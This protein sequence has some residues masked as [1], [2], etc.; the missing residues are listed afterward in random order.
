[1]LKQKK[2]FQLPP[3]LRNHHGTLRTVGFEI[4]FGSL[5]A[6][7]VANF[8]QSAFGGNLEEIAPDQFVVAD[9]S[10]GDFSVK[11]DTRIGSDPNPT[12]SPLQ[13]ELYKAARIALSVV[14]PHEI[15]TPPV[16]IDR[17]DELLPMMAMLRSAGAAGSGESVLY[18]FALHINPEATSFEAEDIALTLKSFSL[19]SPWLWKSIGPDMTRR[20]LGFAE[21]F[22]RLYV[23]KLVR[24]DYWPSLPNLIDDYID[25]NPSRNRDL[26]PLP[27]FTFLDEERVRTK[28]PNEKIGKRPTF[29][30]RL[31]DARVNDPNWS[32]ATEWNRWV[33]VER[34][35]ADREK[36]LV[37]CMSYL[38]C[39][40]DNDAWCSQ[41]PGFVLK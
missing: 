9:T 25:A 8:V 33:A 14:I 24:E 27:L 10:L 26:D 38:R 2:N 29:H 32:L 21:P 13:E 30:Y 22:D 6:Q 28:L 23:E 11:L 4:E 17:M 31:P 40:G 5:E 39:A 3:S 20:L 1:M 12:G 18:A 36:L 34:L 35:A 41:A 16:P 7:R 37:A 15:V 19:L